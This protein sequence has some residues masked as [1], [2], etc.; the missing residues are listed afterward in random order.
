KSRGTLRKA[1]FDKLVGY[2]ASHRYTEFREPF[3][4]SG[5]ISFALIEHGVNKVWCNDLD[6]GISSLWHAVFNDSV[7]LEAL[8]SD[9]VPC[10]DAFHSYKSELLNPSDDEDP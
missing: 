3:F 6:P 9:F 8:I 2:L 10:V 1:I 5:A 7:R 4:G